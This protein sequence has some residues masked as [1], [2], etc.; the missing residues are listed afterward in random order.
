MIEFDGIW[1]I[2]KKKVL[3]AIRSISHHSFCVKRTVVLSKLNK[4]LTDWQAI[5][6][7]P[8]MVWFFFCVYVWLV[9]DV[10]GAKEHPLNICISVFHSLNCVLLSSSSF[11]RTSIQI[12]YASIYIQR[13]LFW[14][15]FHLHV[16]YCS[17]GKSNMAIRIERDGYLNSHWKCS[18]WK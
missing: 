10:I 14:L 2:I 7:Q 17:F 5:N 9:L 15:P 4:I 6:E 12:L 3:G 11:F 18:N 13:I 1:C 8:G 16:F